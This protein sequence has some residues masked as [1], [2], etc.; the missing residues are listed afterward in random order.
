MQ[1]GAGDDPVGRDVAAD[2]RAELAE[3]C[4][5]REGA[6]GARGRRA[7]PCRGVWRV[8]RRRPSTASADAEDPGLRA[9]PSSPARSS[10][11]IPV[12]E[13]RS[14][15][16]R[17]HV[18]HT[19][20]LT[21]AS[22]RMGDRGGLKVD[23]AVSSQLANVAEAA[24]QAGATRLRLL[25]DGR[26]QPRPVPAAGA[27]RR[28]HHDDRTGHEH[29]R[30]VRPQSDDRRQR[31]VGSAGLLGGP[32]Q[33]G[34]RLTDQAAHREAIQ[35]AVESAGATHARVRAGA[36]RDLVVLAGRHEARASKATSTPT[37]S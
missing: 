22:S 14:S 24:T 16:R 1:S 21:V 30:G 27:G 2:E 7:C 17:A 11:A 3:A 5:C 8:A 10:C 32:L 19:E 18:D 31:R 36:A 35:H 26:D 12:V 9:S 37:S 13:R 15:H 6:R 29:R 23:G 34:S 20:L 28:T 33:S 25:L 4:P